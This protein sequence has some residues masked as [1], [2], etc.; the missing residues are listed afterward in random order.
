M[1][2]NPNKLF[3]PW[4]SPITEDDV[5]HESLNI[6]DIHIEVDFELLGVNEYNIFFEFIWISVRTKHNAQ[7]FFI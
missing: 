3:I 5:I 6:S 4:E 7:T 1:P 2:S